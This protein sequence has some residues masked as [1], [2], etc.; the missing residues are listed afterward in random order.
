MGCDKMKYG[1]MIKTVDKN[2]KAYNDF[3]YPKRGKVIAKD[4]ND[5]PEC[6]GGLHGLIHETKYHYIQNNDIWLVLKYEKGM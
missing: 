3:K 4:W 6:G 5:K 1:Y 2:M